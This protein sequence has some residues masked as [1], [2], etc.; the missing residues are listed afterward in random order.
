MTKTRSSDV[1]AE[2]FVSARYAGPSIVCAEFFGRAV[3]LGQLAPPF[4]R[5]EGAA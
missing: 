4:V 1:L 5:D 2:G 3:A